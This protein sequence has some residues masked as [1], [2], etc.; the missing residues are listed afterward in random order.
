MDGLS[1]DFAR[2]FGHLVYQAANV[3]TGLKV[4]LAA[5]VDIRPVHVLALAEPYTGPQLRQVVKSLAK[6]SPWPDGALDRLVELIGRSKS[7]KSLRNYVAH[8]RWTDGVR[9]GAIKPI[10]MKINNEK[11]E[12][13]GHKDDEK[14]WLPNEIMKAAED[15]RKFCGDLIAFN[16]EFGLTERLE[17]RLP[18]KHGIAG[19]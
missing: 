3:E 9:D 14:D 5:M 18:Q 17:N 4:C 1:D 19:N 15:L 10:G 2:A 11:I 12:T 7:H 8:S 16:D 13:F 6:S